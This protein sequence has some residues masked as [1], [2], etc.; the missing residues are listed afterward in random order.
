MPTDWEIGDQI[1]VRGG[2]WRIRNLDPS[3]ACLA[4]ELEGVDRT[5]G[6][7]VSTLLLPFERPVRIDPIER[8]FQ[9]SPHRLAAEL[10]S[11]AADCGAIDELHPPASPGLAVLPF[12]LEPAW[13]LVAGRATRVL[14]ADEVG[15]GKTI[16]AG[17]AI[18]ELTARGW[19]ER[20]LIVTPAGLREQWRVEL[21]RRLAIAAPIVDWPELSRRVADRPDGSNPWQVPGVSIVS[22]DF[23]KQPE[24]FGS[25]ADTRWDLLVVDEAHGAT[26]A[27]RRGDVVDALARGARHVLL[28]TA[29]PH[30]GDERTFNA[31]VGLGALDEADR[32]LV[33]RRDR[34]VL[35][36]PPRRTRVLRIASGT[37][38]R[39]LHELLE[40]YAALVWRSARGVEGRAARLAMLVLRKRAQSSAWAAWRS[41]ERRRTLLASLARAAAWE[42]ARHDQ[43]AL[44]FHDVTAPDGDELPDRLLAA[45]GLPRLEAELAWLGRLGSAAL[46]ATRADRKLD[47]L[48]RLVARAGQPVLIFSEYR[49]TQV[50]VARRLR[51]RR[52]ACLHGSQTAGD[53]RAALDDFDAG[54]AD[55]LL[56][57][58]AASEGLNLHARCRLLVN[59]ELP[60][61]PSR[62]EQRAGRLDRCGQSRVVHVVHLVGRHTGEIE[63]LERL[64]VQQARIASALGR[65]G[66]AGGTVTRASPRVAGGAG[67]QAAAGVT[68][69]EVGR[70]APTRLARRP[71]LAV[72][73]PTARQSRRRRAPPSAPRLRRGVYYVLATTLTD[74]RGRRLETTAIVVTADGP[75]NASA[76]PASWVDAHWR[77]SSARG[78]AAA[79]E[80][81]QRRASEL[82]GWLERAHA[83]RRARGRLIEAERARRATGVEARGL[84]DDI[85]WTPR[86]STAPGVAAPSLD[87][88]FDA[89]IVRP[90]VSRLAAV[91]LVP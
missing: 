32:T 86:T 72:L 30:D 43:P 83:L 34:T 69:S 88:R 20:V 8:P 9:T 71:P 65:A 61:S 79:S 33:F 45:P 3:P 36:R 31:L 40:A 76:P 21:D 5:N 63:L 7:T 91:L 67:V 78:R 59:V 42:G 54:R 27:T 12:Q 18:R 90:G 28:L 77:A 22:I 4:A 51:G 26:S 38:L 53:R 47:V 46:V 74:A 60:W 62:L 68:R 57:T 25:L 24:V 81:A 80:A 6:D 70:R 75:A 44:P 48:S 17:L 41:I 82:T 58:D 84:F 23:L 2:L 13:A 85:G 1:A 73:S 49:D 56:A 87:D 50:E 11:L 52:L 16:Q 64:R 37:P 55:V 14:V 89:G 15:L 35:R 10:R 66:A 29:T 19:A 39:R